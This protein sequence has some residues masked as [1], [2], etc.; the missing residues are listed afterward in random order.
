MRSLVVVLLFA[1]P[2]VVLSLSIRE[3]VVVGT[4]SDEDSPLEE[5]E[6][7][8]LHCSTDE[9]WI[10]CKWVHEIEDV[11]DSQGHIM[12]VAC[13]ASSGHS[14]DKCDNSAGSDELDSYAS[15]ITFDVSATSC[16]LRIQNA[17]PRDTG[18]WKCN[19]YD[20]DDSPQYSEVNAFVSN[21]SRIFITEPDLWE[22]PN[23]VV[24]YKIGDNNDEIEVTCTAYGGNPDPVFH[25]YIGDDR[26]EIEDIDNTRR[27][28][29]EDDLGKYVS[30]QM[31]Y[32][33]SRSDLCKF[34][35]LTNY[36]WNDQFT[37]NLICKVEQTTGSKT[38]YRDENDQQMVEVVVEV[39]SGAA[40]NSIIGV[41]GPML[42]L[43]TCFYSTKLTSVL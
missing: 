23:E 2:T 26:N 42:A 7:L 27:T 21:Q 35:D 37:F 6:E 33:P 14:G 25:W 13:G 28:E 3:A 41:F 39:K 20:A 5:G 16:G 4:G 31:T 38:Y 34:D 8:R 15:R 1:V 29:S 32:K 9:E 22:D 36:C 30:E 10:L 43:L 17:D 18:K 19:I 24:E 12:K 11:Y 40:R